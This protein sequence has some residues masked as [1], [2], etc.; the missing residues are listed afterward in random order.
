MEA[1]QM[2]ARRILFFASVAAVAVGIRAEGFGPKGHA[3]IGSIADRRLAGRP[4]ASKV[5]ALLDGMTLSEAAL[6]PDKIRAWDKRGPT[7]PDAFQLPQHKGIEQELMDFHRAN[8]PTATDPTGSVANH[9]WF[10]YTDVP[11]V[12]GGDLRGRQGRS[13]AI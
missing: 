9:Q 10:H 5:S 1:R 8:P 6:L 13:V 7:E 11:A 3:T 12:A 2:T 4:A